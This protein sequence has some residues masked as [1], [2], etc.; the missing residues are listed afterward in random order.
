MQGTCTR[1]QCPLSHEAP[2]L[3]IEVL[4]QA[5]AC[6]ELSHGVYCAVC[7]LFGV[8]WWWEHEFLIRTVDTLKHN[9][10]PQGVCVCGGMRT[11]ALT[12][13]HM[14]D[15]SRPQVVARTSYLHLC[16]KLP[17]PKR[18]APSQGEQTKKK[19]KKQKQQQKQKKRLG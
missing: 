4:H 18:G 6:I 8:R 19:Q 9:T 11:R 13:A 7:E 14:S 3:D 2:C 1:P 16:K 17:T 15:R 10:T 5:D 12:R